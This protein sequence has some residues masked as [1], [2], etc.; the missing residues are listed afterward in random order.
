[1]NKNHLSSPDLLKNQNALH[2]MRRALTV[3]S[4][5]GG[6]VWRLSEHHGLHE[7]LVMH[8]RSAQ[9][10]AEP[11]SS[12]DSESLSLHP[13]AVHI[14]SRPSRVVAHSSHAPE[15]LS[16]RESRTPSSRRY[17]EVRTARDT[18]H[19]ASDAAPSVGTRQ[20]HRQRTAGLSASRDTVSDG[21]QW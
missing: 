17:R 16:R 7:T 9:P 6:S 4:V 8:S 10:G 20:R 1:M 13:L 2:S 19:A 12:S 14:S 3:V 5:S 11:A 21:R 18:R 15:H